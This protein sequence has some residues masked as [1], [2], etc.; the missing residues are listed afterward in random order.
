MWNLL[1]TMVVALSAPGAVGDAPDRLLSPHGIEL[2]VDENV[3]VFFAALNAAGYADE[4]L[5]KGPPLRAPVFHPLRRSTRQALRKVTESKAVHPLIKLF[6]DNPADVGTYLKALVSADESSLEKLR[7]EA[8]PILQTFREEGALNELFDN[9]ATDQRDHAVR[10]MRSAT[11]DMQ[12]ALRNFSGEEFQAPSGLI[13]VP[14]PLDSHEGVHR[15]VTG[16]GDV[17]VI[18]GPGDSTARRAVVAEALRPTVQRLVDRHYGSARS[19]RAAWRRVKRD[20]AVARRYGDGP[21]YLTDALVHALAWQAFVTST[22]TPRRKAENDFL[23]TEARADR[24]WT[25]GA[26]A[27]VRSLRGKKWT[28]HLG[29]VLARS[30]P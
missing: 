9:L 21:A 29:R 11:E 22:G 20:R 10:L 7:S 4:S 2:R 13:V 30:A 6:D 14:N 15:I 16:K 26:L 19:F 18:V 24:R 3:F 12:V 23:D 28:R 17:W 25:A 8:Q 5:R 1:T 27:I